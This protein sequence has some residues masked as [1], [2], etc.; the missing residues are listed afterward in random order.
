MKAGAA[1]IAVILTAV[2]AI[3]GTRPLLGEKQP[4]AKLTNAQA[5]TMLDQIEK[6]IKE[7]YYDPSMHGLDLDKKFEAARTKIATAMSQDDALLAIAGAVSSLNDSHTR[8]IPPA[9][10]YNVDYGFTMKAIG[11]SDCYVTA[12]RQ[13]SDA[14]AKGLK[15]GDQIVSINGVPIT[16]QDLLSIEYGYYVFPQSGFHLDVQSPEGKRRALTVLAKVTQGQRSISDSDLSAWLYSH[17]SRKDQEHYFGLDDQVQ[18]FAVDKKVL[19]CKLSSFSIEPSD[20]ANQIKKAGA[21]ENIVLDLRGN[22]GGRADTLD[23]FVG[24]FFDHDVKIG[25]N[26]RRKGS[27][28]EVAKGRGKGAIGGKLIVLIDSK[29]GSAAEIFSRVIQLEKRGTIIGDRSSGRVMESEYL[30][31][32]VY[33]DPMNVTQYG[34]SIT[35]ADCIMPDGKSLEGAGVVPDERMLPTP[36]DLFAGRDPVLA[37][38]AALAG[39]ELSPEKAGE[40]F[41]FKWPDNPEIH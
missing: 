27:K 39:A 23:T 20:L 10:P 32:A 29:S 40:L 36:A 7:K 5:L 31:H 2:L 17:R 15:R 37:R 30:V 33:L 14:E 6:D 4:Y 25:D 18:F 3:S 8:F 41:P 22:R 26:K 1:K 19:F 13:G 24:G 38:A 34:T 16:R 12:V 28:P 9:R 21:F 11:D 35:I